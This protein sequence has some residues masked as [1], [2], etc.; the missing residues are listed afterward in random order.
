MHRR[1]TRAV[2][3]PVV[4]VP[5]MAGCLWLSLPPNGSPLKWLS[6]PDTLAVGR[7]GPIGP[8]DESLPETLT[9]RENRS[10]Q[11]SSIFLIGVTM[12]GNN[13]VMM[14]SPTIVNSLDNGPARVLIMVKAPKDGWYI[15]NCV[16]S[17]PGAR[18]SLTSAAPTP[19]NVASWDYRNRPQ[20]MHLYPAL[21]ELRA[22]VHFFYWT[23]ESG[24]V[25]F[26]ETHILKAKIEG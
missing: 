18:A 1:R 8:A 17:G 14:T 4:L 25:E 15:V 7:S 9:P 16:I 23:L 24:S 20:G 3:S 22:G 12:S 21:V 2:L 10:L 5:I 13:K 19:V 6:P 26:L 11:G